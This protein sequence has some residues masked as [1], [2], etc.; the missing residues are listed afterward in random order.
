M[1]MG[2]RKGLLLGACA[3]AALFLWG[4]FR[5]GT[6]AELLP[7]KPPEPVPE[8]KEIP[9]EPQR[10]TMKYDA[11]RYIRT[12]PLSDPFRLDAAPAPAEGK[13]AAAKGASVQAEPAVPVLQGI[14]ILGADRRAMVLTDGQ[15]K[16]VKEGEQVGAWTVTGIAEKQVVLS[17]PAGQKTLTL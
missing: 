12:K 4:L 9:P 2:R 7:E 10:I 11:N 1:N 5:G 13:P 15:T 3:A 8:K 17:G 14:L 6:A 16:T